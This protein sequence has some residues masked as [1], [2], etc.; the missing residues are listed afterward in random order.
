MKVAIHQPNYL[1]WIGY[2]YKMHRSG[3]F[4]FLDN[5][6][7]SKR[8][9]T[10]RVKVKK[11]RYGDEQRWLSV[12]VQRVHHDTLINE[13]VVDDSTDW[14]LAHK[15]KLYYAYGN[16]PHFDR[17]AGL[18]EY[19]IAEAGSRQLAMINQSIIGYLSNY[20]N[21]RPRIEQSSNLGITG[22][23]ADVNISIMKAVGE[24]QYISGKGADKY[25][26]RD[27]YQAAGIDLYYADIAS[28]LKSEQGRTLN[29]KKA[30]IGA[31][32]FEWLMLYTNT[33]IL[34]IFRA[35]DK[36]AQSDS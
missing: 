7:Y 3:L 13:L 25:Q 23:K 4:V 35:A 24:Q 1:P 14:W 16:S 19:A 34:H 28:F 5:V 18:V 15:R 17:I 27:Q 11:D 2:F 31:S 8:S 20:L 10:K 21:V 26:T 32:I 29:Y 30:A 9:Y 33:E 22:H 36:Y 6:Q 12:P